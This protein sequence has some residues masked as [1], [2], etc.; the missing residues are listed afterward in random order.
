MRRA[1][2]LKGSR[3][4]HYVREYEHLDEDQDQDRDDSQP[5]GLSMEERDDLI[6][7]AERRLVYY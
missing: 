3:N 5:L 4:G 2:Y 7:P 1:L 6:G